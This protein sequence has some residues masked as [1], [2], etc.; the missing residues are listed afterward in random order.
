MLTEENINSI[1]AYHNDARQSIIKAIEKG[2]T[3][4]A[5]IYRKLGMSHTIVRN[6]L[7]V[8]FNNKI[9][10]RCG[11]GGTYSYSVNYEIVDQINQLKIKE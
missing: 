8:L 6:N 7:T 9:I 1:K 11:S 10:N 3:K 2:F 5:Q 4:S